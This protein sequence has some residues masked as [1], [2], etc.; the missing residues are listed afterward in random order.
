MPL[1]EEE[2][3]KYQQLVGEASSATAPQTST[4]FSPYPGLE[5]QG[6]TLGAKPSVRFAPPKPEEPFKPTESERASTRIAQIGLQNVD[7]V[8]KLLQVSGTEAVPVVAHR[9]PITPSVN[10]LLPFDPTVIRN[11]FVRDP[12][13]KQLRDEIENAI[14]LLALLRTGKAGETSQIKQIRST[15]TIGQGEQDDPRTVIRRLNHLERE[16]RGFATGEIQ[17]PLDVGESGLEAPVLSP[18]AQTE[19]ERLLGR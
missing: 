13:K 19:M 18:Q 5:L 2:L 8:R 4:G 6:L 10:S 9:R 11:P 17:S 7:R 14:S 1:T 3:Q 16:F 15:S 12:E